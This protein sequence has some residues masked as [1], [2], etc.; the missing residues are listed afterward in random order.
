NKLIETHKPDHMIVCYDRPEKGF[1]HELYPAYKAN[2]SAPPEDLVPQFE[3]I[4]EFIRTYPIKSLAKPGFE[5]DDLIATLVAR[6]KTIPDMQIYIVTSDKDLMQLVDDNVFIYDTMKEK[7]ITRKEVVEKFGVPPEK[8]IDVQSLSGDPTDNIPGIVGVGPKTAT[9]LVLEYGSLEAV[10]DHA[11]E[12]KG[13]LGEKIAQ[14]RAN[15]LLSRQLVTLPTQVETQADWDDLVQ[16]PADVSALNTFYQKLDFT[17]FI[18][19]Q[20]QETPSVPQTQKAVFVGITSLDELKALVDNILQTKPQCLAFDTETD[21]LDAH[22]A[23]LV[24]LSLCYQQDK[25]YYLPLAHREGPNLP[26]ADVVRMISPL[27]VSN[28]LAKAGQNSKFDLNVL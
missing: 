22:N 24:G 11:S 13:K 10:L 14:G 3:I 4:N 16:P 7:I 18:S 1:R 15:A 27:L 8:V 23:T 21:S 28:D 6:Y 12:I 20:W 5:A 17:K 25:A 2:R 19:R 26:F 9:K